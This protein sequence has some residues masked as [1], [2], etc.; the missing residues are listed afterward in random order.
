MLRDAVKELYIIDQYLYILLPKYNR[1]SFFLILRAYKV[2]G[3]LKEG[4]EVLSVSLNSKSYKQFEYN[5]T[6]R[7][8]YVS[9]NEPILIK[10]DEIRIN[11]ILQ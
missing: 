9:L 2:L 8:L 1:L 6:T 11:I 5:T 4:D 10:G 7:E 3:L